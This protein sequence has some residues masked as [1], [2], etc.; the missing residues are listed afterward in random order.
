MLSNEKRKEQ[1]NYRIHVL[2]VNM[3]YIYKYV[4]SIL[5]VPYHYSVKPKKIKIILEVRRHVVIIELTP[6]KLVL[7][8]DPRQEEI[9]FYS[10]D[11]FL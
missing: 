5:R 1:A 9:I 6:K 7:T 10:F 3:V 2:W 11:D 8:N 4:L